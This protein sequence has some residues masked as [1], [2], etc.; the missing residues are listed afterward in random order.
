MEDWSEKLH[1]TCDSSSSKQL[2]VSAYT[3]FYTERN[4]R[5]ET[6][7]ARTSEDMAVNIST[8]PGVFSFK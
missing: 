6:L 4:A 8:D 7:V 3:F 1:N 5:Q 2:W